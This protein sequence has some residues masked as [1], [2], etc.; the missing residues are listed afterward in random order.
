MNINPLNCPLCGNTNFCG[1]ISKSGN[2]AE[3]W[4][5]APEIMFPQELIQQVPSALRD[6]ACICKNCVEK[7]NHQLARQA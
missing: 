2:A 1:N 7:F 4:C 3:C 5:Q 6:K